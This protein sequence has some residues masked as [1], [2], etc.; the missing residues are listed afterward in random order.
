MAIIFEGRPLTDWTATRWPY[1]LYSKLLCYYFPNQTE[2]VEPILIQIGAI[3][4]FDTLHPKKIISA[5][6]FH[7][8][9]L[10][11]QASY[12]FAVIVFLFFGQCDIT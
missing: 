5:L 8:L 2:Q 3:S 1:R 4:E 6:T 9:Y 12:E 7:K 11:N 10:K